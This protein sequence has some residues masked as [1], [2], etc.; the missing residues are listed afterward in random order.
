[1]DKN[2]QSGMAWYFDALTLVSPSSRAVET[3]NPLDIHGTENKS[4]GGYALASKI[5]KSL[6]RL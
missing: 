3:D 1:M 5:E 6:I 4:Q 2:Y